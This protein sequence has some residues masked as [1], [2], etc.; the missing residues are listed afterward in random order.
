MDRIFFEYSDVLSN[1]LRVQRLIFEHFCLY[2]TLFLMDQ[3]F[4]E[5]SEVLPNILLVQR[6]ILNILSAQIKFFDGRTSF[7]NIRR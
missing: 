7:L 4:F 1:I 6:L 5:Y 3:L 2:E